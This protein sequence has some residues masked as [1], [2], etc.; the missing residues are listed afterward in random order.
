MAAPST[1]P[2]AAGSP[3]PFGSGLLFAL[4][5]AVFL[6]FSLVSAG[7]ALVTLLQKLGQQ[8][9]EDASAAGQL[10]GELLITIVVRGFTILPALAVLCLALL[11]CRYRAPWF[12]W[13]LLTISLPLLFLFP[14]GTGFGIWFLLYLRKHRHEFPKSIQAEQS[15]TNQPTS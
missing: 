1:L 13:F 8:G 2:P 4:P 10:V 14:I 11:A 12:F 7:Q 3:S 9:W 6:V 5:G 15:G